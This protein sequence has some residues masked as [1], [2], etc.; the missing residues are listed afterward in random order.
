M[1]LSNHFHSCVFHDWVDVLNEGTRI[2]G[3]VFKEVLEPECPIE[4]FIMGMLSVTHKQTCQAFA[5]MLGMDWTDLQGE[6]SEWEADF[7][8]PPVTLEQL[9]KSIEEWKKEGAA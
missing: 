2:W 8:K 3:L 7:D 9:R 6:V 5:R 4:I 1:E